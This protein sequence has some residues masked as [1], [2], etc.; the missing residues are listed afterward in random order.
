MRPSIEQNELQYETLVDVTQFGTILRYLD[1]PSSAI[2]QVILIDEAI[3]LGR[4]AAVLERAMEYPR[5]ERSLQ[6]WFKAGLARELREGFD[7]PQFFS[8]ED[9]AVSQPVRCLYLPPTYLIQIR[10]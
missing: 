10:E 9:T 2:Y 4:Y 8:R 6:E 7:L 1:S 5:C 3:P